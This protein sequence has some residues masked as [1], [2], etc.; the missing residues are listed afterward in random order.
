VLLADHADARQEDL[1]SGGGRCNFTTSIPRRIGI[2]RAILISRAR[3]LRAYT[4]ADFLELVEQ[5][6]I[7]W[8]EKTLGQLFCDGSAKQIVAMLLDQCEQG[9]LSSDWATRP[10][11][12]AMLTGCSAWRLAR[13]RSRRRN[14]DRDRWAIDPEDGRDRLCV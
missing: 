7:A 6:G 1:I 10:A 11:R 8:H 4:A 9:R 5:Y 13:A 12:S 2:C 3:R 14:C